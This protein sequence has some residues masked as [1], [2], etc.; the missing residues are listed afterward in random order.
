MAVKKITAL[1]L[2]VTIALLT[3][4]I[5]FWWDG[6]FSAG[7][8]QESDATWRIQGICTNS[9]TGLPIL[10]VEVTAVFREPIAFKHHDRNPPPLKTTTV[11]TSTDSAGRFDVRGKGGYVYLQ[12]AKQGYKEPESWEEWDGRVF[13]SVKLVQTNLHLGLLPL[14]NRTIGR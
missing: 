6:G 4:V 8:Y 9:V 10:G 12:T 11:K 5:I 13:N 14:T 3:L 2:L 1:G 7:P